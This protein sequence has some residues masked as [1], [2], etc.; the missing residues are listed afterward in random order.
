MHQFNSNVILEKNPPIN[1]LSKSWDLKYIALLGWRDYFYNSSLTFV[2]LGSF[3]LAHWVS[4]VQDPISTSN[5]YF[6]RGAAWRSNILCWPLRGWP[7]SIGLVTLCYRIPEKKRTFQSCLESAALIGRAIKVTI[8]HCFC[9][10]TVP[11]VEDIQFAE[12]KL[13]KNISHMKQQW[14]LSFIRLM[15]L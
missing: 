13:E 5:T 2:H 14:L 8:N 10:I 11:Q 12:M 7:E 4:L 3:C 1:T 6:H 15:T 9:T